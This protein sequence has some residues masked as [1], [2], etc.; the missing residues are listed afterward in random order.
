MPE[1]KGVTMDDFQQFDLNL[2]KGRDVSG[3]VIGS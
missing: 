3:K 2:V 1:R